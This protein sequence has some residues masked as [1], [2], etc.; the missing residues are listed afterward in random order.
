MARGTL[1]RVAVAAPAQRRPL[2]G[3]TA[4][5]LIVVLRVLSAVAVFQVSG[6]AHLAGDLVEYVTLGHHVVDEAEDENDPNH[7]CP[8][9]CPT[10][11][12]VHFSGASLPATVSLP[13]TW[14]PMSE[15]RVA[16]WVRCAD[17][18]ADPELPSVFRPPKA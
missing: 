9:G 17:A 10:C 4:A 12:H 8:P 15:G 11:H 18:P 13:L 2:R 16:E 3:K 7:Q 1:T 6:A 5:L 14:V